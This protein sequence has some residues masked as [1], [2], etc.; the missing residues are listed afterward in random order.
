M[1]YNDPEECVKGVVSQ[2][3]R[4]E[5]HSVHSRE[6]GNV[7]FAGHREYYSSNAAV[8]ETLLLRSPAVFLIF[9]QP[10]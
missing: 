3:T 7:E 9:K 10:Y 1:L 6:I 2:T 5:Y 8:L 4:I